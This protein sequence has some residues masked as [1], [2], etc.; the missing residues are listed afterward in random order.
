MVVNQAKHFADCLEKG[1]PCLSPG[2]EAIKSVASAEAI[3]KAAP[4]GGTRKVSW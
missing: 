2:T 3:L 4:K 1:A